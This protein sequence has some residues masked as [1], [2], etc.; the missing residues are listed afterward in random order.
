[1]I[2][3]LIIY[4]RAFFDWW[5]GALRAALRVNTNYS[6]RGVTEVSLAG[7]WVTIRRNGSVLQRLSETEAVLNNGFSD[8]IRRAKRITGVLENDQVMVVDATLP[9]AAE[10]D[11]S[12]AISLQLDSLTPFNEDEA[13]FDCAIIGRNAAQHIIHVRLAVAPRHRISEL[14]ALIARAGKQLD[15]V[16]AAQIPEGFSRQPQFSLTVATRKNYWVR[17]G[18]GILATAMVSLLVLITYVNLD[19]HQQESRMLKAL[20]VNE[21][22][23]VQKT[24]LL[25]QDIS[26][27]QQELTAPA[28]RR[29]EA[30][31]IIGLLEE[32]T[33]ILPDDSWIIDIRLSPE[34]IDFTGLSGNASGLLQLF[35]KSSM[36]RDATFS[37]PMTRDK[38][39]NLER[40]SISV[41]VIPGLQ[42]SSSRE[43]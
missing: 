34:K 21:L 15:R 32:V 22:N 10:A 33:R 5:F 31:P 19:R 8:L 29:L 38:Q 30:V 18:G 2:R 14:S 42:N 11:L 7:G 39:L 13:C 3:S 43:G 6:G 20:L 9:E 28:K 35:E 40:F 26:E 1:M 37:A 41:Q 23:L 17:V 4:T 24:K 25:E 27:L 16:V 36:F 12:E